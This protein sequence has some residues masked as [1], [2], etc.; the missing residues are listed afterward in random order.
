M[1]ISM[2]GMPKG[3]PRSYPESLQYIVGNV[4]GYVAG[5]R[6]MKITTA[7]LEKCVER[8]N[9]TRRQIV[10]LRFK[11]G[12]TNKQIG[13]T[14]G[15]SGKDVGEELRGAIRLIRIMAKNDIKRR[16]TQLRREANAGEPTIDILGLP[17]S[18]MKYLKRADII[19][20]SDLTH[21][22]EEELRQVRNI[23]NVRIAHI[24]QALANNGLS[25]S[26]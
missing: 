18:I 22:T 21:L 3:M 9:E 2:R 26:R 15:I 19:Y 23:G 11:T 17:E 5:S 1:S 8:L 7:H 6:P 4:S 10:E 16:E 14:L 24:K 25:L 12:M 20:M 13:E